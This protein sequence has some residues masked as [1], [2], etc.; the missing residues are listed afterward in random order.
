MNTKFNVYICFI[1]FPLLY[2]DYNFIYLYQ[3]Y[4]S[5]IHIFRGYVKHKSLR[6]TAVDYYY[7]RMRLNPFVRT[8]VAKGPIVPAPA[9]S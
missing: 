8:S 3:G 5:Y 6:T 2:Y 4:A 9:D 1:L 7:G